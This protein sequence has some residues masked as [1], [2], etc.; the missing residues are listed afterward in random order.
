MARC[1]ASETGDPPRRGGESKRRADKSRGM[2]RPWKVTAVTRDEGNAAAGRF[3]TTSNLF[4]PK[5]SQAGGVP[6]IN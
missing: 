2:R 3:P 6:I 1:K 4:R 5:R